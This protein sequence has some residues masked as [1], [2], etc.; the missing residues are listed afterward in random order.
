[1]KKQRKDNPGNEKR[2]SLSDPDSKISESAAEKEVKKKIIFKN[3]QEPA[4][5]YFSSPCLLSEMEDTEE[6]YP[7]EIIGTGCESL[8][9][10]SSSNLIYKYKLILRKVG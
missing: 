2:I 5:P 3:H 8:P 9:S 10:Y 4:R 6:P 1:M 7:D